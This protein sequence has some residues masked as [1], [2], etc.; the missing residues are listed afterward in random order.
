[1]KADYF[2]SLRYLFSKTKYNLVSF[3]SK[4]SIIVLTIAYFSFLT[5]LSV[6]SGLE[7]YSLT[8][9][10]SFDPD[11]K[12]EPIDKNYISDTKIDS[13]LSN[14]KGIEKY[15]KVVKGNVVD[16]FEGKTEYAE[17]YGVDNSFNEV[18]NI[19]SIISVGRYPI[20]NKQEVL[21]LRDDPNI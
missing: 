19:D 18:I 15:S 13:L 21:L 12:I 8:F 11:I 2:I 9:S 5:I 10:K 1:M 3:I 16:Q 14:F 7:D 6:F 20:L 17:L 4:F